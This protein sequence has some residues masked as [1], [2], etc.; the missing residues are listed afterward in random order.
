MMRL[1]LLVEG[2]SE[3]VFVRDVL[4][5]HYAQQQV[6]ITPIIVNTSP[7]FK[8]GV[9]SYAKVKPQLI[10]L[11]RQ[12]GSAFV[13]TIFDLYALPND[14]PG[15]DAADYPFQG[16]G[17]QKAS[18]IEDKLTQ[19]INERN[20]IPNLLVHEFEALLFT[21]PE[22]FGDWA[23]DEECV[24]ELKAAASCH[25]SPEDINESPQMAPS[26]R[27]LAAMPGY[28]KPLHGALIAEAIGIDAM[29][30]AC[31]HFHGWLQKI[32]DLGGVL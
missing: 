4:A 8:G 23:N 5:P 20:F 28:Q 9:V 13:S 11:C 12:D 6:F 3:E 19:N 18:F 21:A 2:Q 29:R 15:K 14:F 10:K 32:D 16:S 26:K 17:H 31:P 22:K 1:L 24:R 27:V 30:A 7:G 25:D